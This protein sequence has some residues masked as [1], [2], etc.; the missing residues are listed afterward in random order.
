MNTVPVGTVQVGTCSYYYW[1]YR[2]AN[3]VPVGISLLGLVIIITGVIGV[4]ILFNPEQSNL[5]IAK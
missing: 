5:N 1:G 3:T 2:G 4:R